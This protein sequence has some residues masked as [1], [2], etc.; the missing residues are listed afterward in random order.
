VMN[1]SKLRTFVLLAESVQL[2]D[3]ENV[4]AQNE[5]IIRNRFCFLL[6]FSLQYIL[7]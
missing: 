2:Y 7:R 5:V 4:D 3:D 1:I 6:V